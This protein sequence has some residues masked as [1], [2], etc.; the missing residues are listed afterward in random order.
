M[1]VTYE[2]CILSSKI[3]IDNN[4]NVIAH[5][6]VYIA[7]DTHLQPSG[8]NNYSIWTPA[9]LH[10]HSENFQNTT[11]DYMITLNNITALLEN[12]HLKK[13]KSHSR[14]IVCAFQLSPTGGD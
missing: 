12:E 11:Y 5:N 9:N 3:S 6:Y 10:I 13:L 4:T 2:H 1:G 14:N 7:A 8:R